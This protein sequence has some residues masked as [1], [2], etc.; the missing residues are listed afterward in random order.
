MNVLQ[1]ISS[2]E[3]AD[4]I[5]YTLIS[6]I[7]DSKASDETSAQ[8]KENLSYSENYGTT[9][10]LQF[11]RDMLSGLL[12]DEVAEFGLRLDSILFG[13][14]ATHMAIMFDEFSFG[15]VA[16]EKLKAIL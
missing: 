14:S 16:R 11:L 6:Q 3:D 12:G 15:D 7:L 9:L 13:D 4:K 2:K 1:G 10:K 8:V 5:I